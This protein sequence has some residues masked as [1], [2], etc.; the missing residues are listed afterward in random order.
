M[1]FSA[2]KVLSPPPS[3][4]GVDL[5][6]SFQDR[7]FF[8]VPVDSSVCGAIPYATDAVCPGR[9]DTPTQTAIQFAAFRITRL[10]VEETP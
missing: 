6:R 7:V 8:G 2:F 1:R 10:A 9:F 5:A 4:F 3:S